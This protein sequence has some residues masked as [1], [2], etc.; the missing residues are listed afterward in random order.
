MLNNVYNSGEMPED[1]SRSVFISLT[2]KVIAI[3]CRLPRTIRFMSHDKKIIIMILK[4][5]PGNIIR[6]DL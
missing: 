5:K 3:E 1:L 4:N 2:K 6:S